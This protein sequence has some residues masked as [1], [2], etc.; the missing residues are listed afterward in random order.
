MCFGFTYEL[1]AMM[2]V[3]FVSRTHN[4]GRGVEMYMAPTIGEIKSVDVC[5]DCDNN[6]LK[7]K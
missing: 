5:V 2:K 7:P 1:E 4:H 6:Y 3:K